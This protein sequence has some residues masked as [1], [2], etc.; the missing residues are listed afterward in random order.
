VAIN[1]L[2][3]LLDEFDALDAAVRDATRKPHGRLRITAPLTFGTMEIA[4]AL[5]AFAAAYPEIELDVSLSAGEPGGRG[6]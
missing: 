1:R 5:N 2:R 6:L 4:P 3:P